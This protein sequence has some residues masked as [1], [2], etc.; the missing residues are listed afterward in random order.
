MATFLALQQ[1]QPQPQQQ[2]QQKRLRAWLSYWVVVAGLLATK[3]A[4]EQ[5]WLRWLV[6]LVPWG[7]E[8]ALFLA[9]WLHITQAGGALLQQHLQPFLQQRL[10]GLLALQAKRDAAVKGL[11]RVAVFTRLLSQGTADRLAGH[12]DEVLLVLPAAVLTLSPFA[13]GW[14]LLFISLLYPAYATVR[15]MGGAS[16]KP[17][18]KAQQQQQAPAYPP[19]PWLRYWV[20]YALSHLL[21]QA[22]PFWSVIQMWAYLWILLPHLD[23]LPYVVLDGRTRVF[24]LLGR[25]YQEGGQVQRKQ[26]QGKT[27]GG[28][29]A[30]SVSKIED[31]AQPPP[32]APLSP[33]GSGGGGTGNHGH[34]PGLRPQ[35]YKAV[36]AQGK[37]DA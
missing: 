10:G 35:Q 22:L 29:K 14:G 23:G 20:V 2:H 17:A 25:L 3:A 12:V 13:A 24:D 7:G 11:L 21:F 18:P 27:E 5:L 36:S 33:E 4:A 32:A 15:A 8:A 6:R 16:G 30:G 37:K 34:S 19:E 26:G 1:P 31:E 28:E 9:I